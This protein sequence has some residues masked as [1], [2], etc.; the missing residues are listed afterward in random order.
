MEEKNTYVSR[1]K[2][3]FDVGIW[4]A[5]DWLTYVGLEHMMGN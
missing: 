2:P 5:Y 1:R 3:V 4:D